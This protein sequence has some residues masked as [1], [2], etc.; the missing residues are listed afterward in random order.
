MNK[1]TGTSATIEPRVSARN[2][3]G[4]SARV[5]GPCSTRRA[6]VYAATPSITARSPSVT[7]ALGCAKIDESRYPI[8]INWTAARA[9]P[10]TSGLS[11]PNRSRR[12]STKDS[13]MN[14][15]ASASCSFEMTTYDI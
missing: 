2:A 9:A 4:K 6:L 12:D 1:K 15:A 11:S 8:P 10:M 3:C 5:P 14:I 7:S 13:A